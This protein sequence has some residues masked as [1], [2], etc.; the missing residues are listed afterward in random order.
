MALTVI[1]AGKTDAQIL[2]MAKANPDTLNVEELMYAASIV[3]N[4]DDAIAF[5]EANAKQ[6]PADWRTN[7]NLADVEFEKGQFD[8]TKAALDAASNNGGAEQAETNFNYA[9]LAMLEG[10][11]TDAA[12]FLGKA[13]GVEQLAEAQAL[14]NIQNG[15]YAKAIE[16]FGNT[17]SNN[18]AL[19]QLLSGNIDKAASILDNVA[20]KNADTYYLSAICAARQDNLAKVCE[21]LKA[22]AGICKTKAAGAATDME[23]AKFWLLDEFKAAIQ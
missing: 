1:K 16:N 22:V 9:L 2:E 4:A 6:N 15:E 21:S 11:T 3:D 20:D 23:F 8:K 14:L 10:N 13:A 18:A 17:V 7:N 5:T 12:A 19:A